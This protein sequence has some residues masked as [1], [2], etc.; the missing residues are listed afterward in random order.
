MALLSVAE[1]AQHFDRHPR[2]VQ[3]WRERGAPF[4][5]A[6]RRIYADPKVLSDWLKK[7]RANVPGPK[8]KQ[9]T[10]ATAGSKAER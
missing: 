5:K 9:R 6:G 7:T 8:P 4:I 3:G 10:S 1:L 2:A